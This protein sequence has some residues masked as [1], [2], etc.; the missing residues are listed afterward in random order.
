MKLIFSELKGQT[1]Q[2]AFIDEGN[3]FFRIETKRIAL[4]QRSTSRFRAL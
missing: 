4:L 2:P 1:F 3:F